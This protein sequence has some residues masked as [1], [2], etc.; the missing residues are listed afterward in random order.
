[1][2][3]LVAIFCAFLVA[4]SCAFVVTDYTRDLKG[5]NVGCSIEEFEAILE[6]RIEESRFKISVFE[7]LDIA[8][9][10]NIIVKDDNKF[11][12]IHELYQEYYASE[13]FYRIVAKQ[14]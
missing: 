5:S 14:K 7:F 11:S 10:L 3:T 1:M 9:D 6:K 12:F 8:V 2:C 13:E 4:K